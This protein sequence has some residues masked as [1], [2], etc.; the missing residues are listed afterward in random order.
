MRTK[1]R[2][3]SLRITAQALPYV[4]SDKANQSEVRGAVAQFGHRD[5]LEP[6]ILCGLLDKQFAGRHARDGRKHVDGSLIPR[7]APERS[8]PCLR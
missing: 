8:A 4:A 3:P 2:R 6:E 1:S 5:R 7:P